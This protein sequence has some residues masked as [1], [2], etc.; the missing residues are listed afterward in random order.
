MALEARAVMVVAVVAVE[1]MARVLILG[2]MAASLAVA[3]GRQ[4]TQIL[5]AMA[6]SVEFALFG[7]VT[8][9]NSHQL[10]QQTNKDI[11]VDQT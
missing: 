10:E 9:A 2:G 6:Q 3:G 4:M 8:F 1:A 11:Y 7:L 5:A